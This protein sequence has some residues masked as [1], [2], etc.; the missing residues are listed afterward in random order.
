[1]RLVA[2]ERRSREQWRCYRASGDWFWAYSG[3]PKIDENDEM[4]RMYVNIKS[5][6]EGKFRRIRPLRERWQSGLGSHHRGAL[7]RVSWRSLLR[8]R[9]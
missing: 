4:E 1:M 9:A 6:I 8:R 2:H 5:T 3:L 7:G